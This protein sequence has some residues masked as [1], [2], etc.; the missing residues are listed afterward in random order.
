MAPSWPPPRWGM[1]G[2]IAEVKGRWWGVVSLLK[3]S[4]QVESAAIIE[5]LGNKLSPTGPERRLHPPLYKN[6]S[7]VITRLLQ[8]PRA[9]QIWNQRPP[10]SLPPERRLRCGSCSNYSLRSLFRCESAHT[11]LTQTTILL[12]LF[13]KHQISQGLRHLVLQRYF[14]LIL[15]QFKRIIFLPC[16]SPS[17]FLWQLGQAWAAFSPLT[18]YQNIPGLPSPHQPFTPSVVFFDIPLLLCA[19]AHTHTHTYVH[20]HASKY[21]SL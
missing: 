16:P 10:T 12:T 3:A 21:T 15:K 17:T 18:Q 6:R 13:P 8:L 19:H 4:W 2:V 9:S 14:K 20:K 11:T 1:H 5:G 7:W